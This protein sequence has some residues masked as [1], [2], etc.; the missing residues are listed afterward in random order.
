[1]DL[2]IHGVNN[3]FKRLYLS[4]Y[5]LTAQIVI[6]NLSTTF[7]AL[8]F[9]IIFNIY[10]FTNGNVLDLQK[11][12]ISNQINQISEYLAKNAIKRILTFDDTCNSVNS[13][14]YGAINRELSRIKCNENNLLN[15]N[16]EDKLPQLDPT[17]TQQYIYSN[18]LNTKLNIRVLADNLIKYADTDDVY[19]YEDKVFISDID[20]NINKNKNNF[21]NLSF[22]KKYEKKYFYFFN[23]IKK[24]FDENKLSKIKMQNK[25]ND[26]ILLMNVIMTQSQT[27]N[28]YRDQENNFRIIFVNPIIKN[29]KVYGAVLI[30]SLLIYK[31]IRGSTQSI[32][33]TN[34][35]LFFISIMFILSLLFSK[36]I[37]T[38]I[39][40]LSRNTN[41]EIDKSFTDLSLIKYPKRKD[42]IGALSDDIKSMSNDLKKRIKEIE[43]F[44]SD[45]SHELKNP[46]TALR[47]SSELLKTQ[48]L[49]NKNREL[50]IKNIISD[51]D[52]INILISDISNYSLTGVEISQEAFHK[53]EIVQ[54]LKEFGEYAS[55]LNINFQYKINYKKIYLN[56]N[57]NKF[58]QVLNNLLYNAISFVPINSKI[59]IYVSKENKNCIIHF[60][61]QGNGIPLIYKNKIFE[62]FYTDRESNK[63]EH[64]GLGLS[65]SRKIIE[66]FGGSIDLINSSHLGFE[67]ACFE[68][69]LPLKDI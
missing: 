33:L 56:L 40:I 39:K 3:F 55:N 69:K 28:I 46:L 57:K 18:F 11:K 68:I 8:L 27:Y 52:R 24:N 54:Y 65:I 47:T 10:L 60:V 5:T 48:N 4:N 19:S 31:D 29:E 20:S 50:L 17:Y 32:L 37:V 36:S 21:D 1:M 2:V 16:Y 35:F 7:L 61:D 44:T 26:N 42:E 30:D 14:V 45:V 15:K 13:N 62:R 58:L 9:L 23:K 53:L 25:K 51:I 49:N 41:L 66:S 6:I 63:N 22:Y 43:E 38:P 67:G 12:L 64:S 34:F 59:L